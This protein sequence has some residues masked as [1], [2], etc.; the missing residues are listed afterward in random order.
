[1]FHDFSRF[2]RRALLARGLAVFGG[3]ALQAAEAG[4][5]DPAVEAH[6]KAIRPT[7]GGREWKLARTT[8]FPT[9]WPPT[10]RTN[11]VRYAYGLDVTLDGSSGVS[12]P[13][14]KIERRAGSGALTVT[15]MSKTVAAVATHGVR[16]HAGWKYTATD[17]QRIL[18]MAFALR[19]APPDDARADQGFRSYYASWLLGNAE[20]AAMIE[21]AHPSF[22]KWLRR[23]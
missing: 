7:T 9:E 22:F 6:W 20:I 1:M 8:W 5:I 21:P 23:K 17:E 10:G 3:G 14:A 13:I 15:P 18:T 4:D 12:Q 19:S 11:W 2:T 16:P